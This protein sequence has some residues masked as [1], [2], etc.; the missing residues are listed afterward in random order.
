[1]TEH[2]IEEQ[3]Q[4]MFLA[5]SHPYPQ[6]I[7]VNGLRMSLQVGEYLYCTPRSN[8]GPWSAIEIGFPSREVAAFMPYCEDPERPTDTVY[9][10]VPLHIVAKVIQEAGGITQ[11]GRREMGS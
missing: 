7:C 1:M 9:G 3:L 11:P 2:E 5:G 10:Y 8:T 4:A 6:V